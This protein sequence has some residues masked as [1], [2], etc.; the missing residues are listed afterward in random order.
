VLL[1]GGASGTGKTTVAKAIARERGITWVQVD[2]LRLAMQWSDVRLPSD[3]A[4]KALYFF[5]RTPGIW[6]LPADRLC[7]GLIAVGVA[8]TDAIGVVIGNHVVQGDPVVIEGDGILPGII[9]HAEVRPHVEAG[10]VRSVFLMPE[11]EDELLRN[12]L[13]RGRG[14]SSDG[15]T[16]QARRVA[17]MNWRYSRWLANEAA[18]RGLPT[19]TTCPWATLSR[20]VL[21]TAR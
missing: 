1:I 20:R 13:D 2:D 14:I 19:V 9:G 10:L 5:L 7:D 8:M 15:V 3:E 12:M 17:E 6:S 18:A 4:T 21:E 11:S 16:P